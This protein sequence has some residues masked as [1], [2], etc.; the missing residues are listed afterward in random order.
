MITKLLLAFLFTLT[1]T[2][3]D[4][5][6]ISVLIVDGINNH[7]WRAATRAVRKFLSATNRFTVDVS[8]SPPAGAPQTD[9]DRWRPS[10]A[11]Y[12]VVIVNF[13]GGHKP[14]GIRWP[15]PV[16]ES[17]ENYVRNGGGVVFLHAANNSFLKWTAY[18]EMIGLGWRDRSFGPGIAVADTGEV[19]VIPKGSG[20]NPGH[21]PRHDF[22]IHVLNHDHPIT[23]DMPSVWLHPSEQ[24]T[25]GQHGPAQGLIILT[26]AK[27]EIS[28]QNEP[29]DWVRSYGKGRVYTTMLGHTWENEPNPN[30][31]CAGFQTLFSRGVEWAAT[32]A[33]TIKIPADFPTASKMSIRKN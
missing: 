2:A 6:T 4:R 12:K 13:N 29:M 22:A 1:A 33:V 14:D 11:E 28:G 5:Q 19:I 10:F 26:Y 16:E 23:K 17:F 30:M 20:L 32:G 21:G 27:S 7:D 25:H 18:N 15:R 9:W 24:L 31:N 3:T 8:T